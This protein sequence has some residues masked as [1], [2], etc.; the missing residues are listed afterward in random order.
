M[1]ISKFPQDVQAV[2]SVPF[3]DL[4]AINTQYKGELNSAVSRVIDSGWYIRG[5]E[6]AN[7]EQRFAEYCGTKFC[8]GVGSGLDALSLTLK[9][10]RQMGLVDVGDEVLV[11][12]NTY[13]ATILA[14][15][16]AELVPVLVEPD[17][18][19]FNMC[20]KLAAEAITQRT[21]VVLPVHLYGRMANM[22]ELSAL[23]ERAGLLLLEDAAQAHG[24]SL[25]GRKAGA[26]GGAAAFS[27]YPGKNLG[28]LGDAG[29]VVTD[30]AELAR[31]VG[32]LGNYGSQE[33]YV[34]LHIGSNSRLDE[35]QA[36]MLLVKLAY[37]DSEAAKRTIVA[38]KY[39]EGL[40]HPLI[41]LPEWLDDASHVHHLFVIRT[42]HRDALQTHLKN[43]GIQTLIHYPVP[44]HQQAA[45]IQ[46]FR[47]LSF[48]ITES[49]H[50][51]V[52]SL[53]MSPVMT[54]EQVNTVI[55]ACNLWSPF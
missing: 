5:R 25:Y 35:I 16:D 23:A 14:V 37:V 44:P 52:L 22:P 29:A 13:I 10:W 21:K 38:K 28:A 1:A 7:F 19:T 32:M 26:W 30:D 41:E 17:E 36:A 3:L 18:K 15:L 42:T 24:A 27:F 6:L 33:K 31:M 55:D 8:V 51:S 2:F 47:H 40:R 9:A 54:N 53:P 45:L 20:P 50:S 12:A 46:H 39:S 11:P 43:K 4:K 34:N 48:P 49:I